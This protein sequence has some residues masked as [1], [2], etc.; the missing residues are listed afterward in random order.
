MRSALKKKKKKFTNAVLETAQCLGRG[1]GG[2]DTPH[3]TLGHLAPMPSL[4][5]LPMSFSHGP[6]W[7]LF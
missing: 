2:Q 4:H 7:H 6:F 1:P 3:I 5:G